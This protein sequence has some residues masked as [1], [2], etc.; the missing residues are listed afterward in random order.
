MPQLHPAPWFMTL[1]TAWLI[2]LFMMKPTLMHMNHISQ[3]PHQ[4]GPQSKNSWP[5]TWH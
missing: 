2:I 1:L 5:W 3:P 4:P